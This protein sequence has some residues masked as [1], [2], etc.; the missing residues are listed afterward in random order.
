M[1]FSEFGMKKESEI[2][3]EDAEKFLKEAIGAC[4]GV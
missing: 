4:Q 1:S 2:Y 3:L